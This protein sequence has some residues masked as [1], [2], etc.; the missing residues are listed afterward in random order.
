MQLS[1]NSKINNL[2]SNFAA[3][4]RPLLAKPHEIWLSA[5]L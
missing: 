5:L 2:R 1:K 3:M 4:R